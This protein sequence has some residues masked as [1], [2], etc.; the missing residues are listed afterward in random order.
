MSAIVS[1]LSAFTAWLCGLFEVTPDDLTKD[2]RG[3]LPPPE[4]GP[5]AF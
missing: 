4:G 5:G 3:N 2:R 1:W